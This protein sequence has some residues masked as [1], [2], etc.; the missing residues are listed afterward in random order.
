MDDEPNHPAYGTAEMV[1]DCA[2]ECAELSATFLSAAAMRLRDNDLPGYRCAM[3]CAAAATKCARE[4]A[5]MLGE[6]AAL[7]HRPDRQERPRL[8][9]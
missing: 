1:R 8:T 9:V 7:D 3:R 5:A 2:A 6:D 4:L